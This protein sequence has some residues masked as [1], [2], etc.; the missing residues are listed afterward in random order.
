M[1]KISFVVMTIGLLHACS[2][3][4]KNKPERIPKIENPTNKVLLSSEIVWE[5]L[6]PARG[7]QSP[8]AGTIWGDRKG[9]VPTGFLAKF[10]D[11]FSSPPHIHNVTYRAVVIKGRI[12][13]DDP[14][15][16]MIWMPHGSFWAQPAGESHITAAKGEEN[17]ALVEIDKGPYL[18]K[19]IEE[20]FDNGERPI[21][22]DATNV[23]WLNSKKT[24]WIAAESK[25]EISFLWDDSSSRGLFVKLPKGFKGTLRTNGSVLYAVVIQGELKYTLP[26]NQETK[27]LDVGSSFSATDKAIHAI[28]NTNNGVMLYI[29]TNGSIKI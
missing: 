8:Q 21:N 25:A 28:A 22:I 20:S 9:E 11:G 23:V 7:D 26:Q 6:N 2:S 17:I 18:V 14:E 24:N 1:K 13:N 29:R 15:A 4:K 19:P 12:H 27:T 3:P 5:K 16:A 10:V